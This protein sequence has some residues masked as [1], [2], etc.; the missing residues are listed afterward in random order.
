MF[1][2]ISHH[3]QRGSRGRDGK[4]E[5]R[6]GRGEERKEKRKVKEIKGRKFLKNSL[7]T[8]WKCKR[9]STIFSYYGKLYLYSI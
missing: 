1:Y 7:S 8:L 5:E 4:R 6:R 2:I 3:I 9:Y